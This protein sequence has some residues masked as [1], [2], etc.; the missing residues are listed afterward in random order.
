M[1]LEEKGRLLSKS[2]ELVEENMQ[3]TRIKEKVKIFISSNIDERYTLV[4]E[5]L[6]LLLLE[7]GMSEAQVIN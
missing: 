4:R 3:G 7:T 5:A 2:L 1:R 6:R